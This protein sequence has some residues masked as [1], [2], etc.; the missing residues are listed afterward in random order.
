MKR[1][2]VGVLVGGALLAG[3]VTTAA[4]GTN[5]EPEGYC[6]A[7]P[8]PPATCAPEEMTSAPRQ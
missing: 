5:S 1:W 2:M 7:N 8:S 3:G 6:G 4:L